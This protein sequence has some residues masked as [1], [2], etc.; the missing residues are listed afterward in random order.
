MSGSSVVPISPALS[1]ATQKLVVGHVRAAIAWL[2]AAVGVLGTS[3][4]QPDL[5][6]VGSVDCTMSNWLTARHIVADGHVTD[7]RPPRPGV[8][9]TALQALL[10]PVG[11]V[12]ETTK[13]SG[14]VWRLPPV[15]TATH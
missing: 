3:T 10:P 2:Y 14:S 15:P 5:P 8:M 11:F 4:V 1:R 9:S 7:V 6:A 13:P 12:V